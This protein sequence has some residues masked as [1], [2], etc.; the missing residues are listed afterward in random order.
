[1]EIHLSLSEIACIQFTG[2]LKGLS[3]R[4]SALFIFVVE[5]CGNF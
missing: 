3:K 2:F 5:I 1:M 4:F